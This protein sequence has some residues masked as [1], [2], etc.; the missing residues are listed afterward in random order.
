MDFDILYSSKMQIFSAK[1]KQ[2][3]QSFHCW[4]FGSDLH[5]VLIFTQCKLV[6]LTEDSCELVYAT[7]LLTRL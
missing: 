5:S 3:L 2:T 4:P 7:V 1:K 6:S